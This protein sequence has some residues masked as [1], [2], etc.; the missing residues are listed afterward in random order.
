MARPPDDPLWESIRDEATADARREPM[1]A[2]FLHATILNHERFEDALSFHLASKLGS[3]T[4]PAMAI[5]E[6]IDEALAADRAISEAV[7]ADIQA[8]RERDPACR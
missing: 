8:V 7:R 2:S 4:I 3:P 1:L 6:V 5:R